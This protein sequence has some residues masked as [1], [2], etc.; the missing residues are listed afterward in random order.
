MDI[1]QLYIS[2]GLITPIPPK[3][4]LD[5]LIEGGFWAAASARIKK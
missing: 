2:H 1:R 3:L 4:T 5:E